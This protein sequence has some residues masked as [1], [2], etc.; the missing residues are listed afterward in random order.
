MEVSSLFFQN[1]FRT[2]GVVFKLQKGNME[3]LLV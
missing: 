2:E 3:Y 1:P